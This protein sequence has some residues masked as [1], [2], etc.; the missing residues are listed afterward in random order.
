MKKI[1]VIILLMVGCNQVENER[2][3]KVSED[4]HE[5]IVSMNKQSDTKVKTAFR[6]LCSAYIEEANQCLK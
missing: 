1:L 4:I 5:C 3:L 6:S 2:C